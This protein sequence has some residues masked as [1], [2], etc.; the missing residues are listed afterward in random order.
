MSSNNEHNNQADKSEPANNAAQYQRYKPVLAHEIARI[1]TQETVK[2]IDNDLSSQTDATLLPTGTVAKTVYYVGEIEDISFRET[3][4]YQ[5]VQTSSEDGR[6]ST[7]ITFDNNSI[8]YEK[9]QNI[10]TPAYIAITGSINTWER[11]GQIGSKI[12]GHTLNEVTAQE[13]ARF[14]INASE[15]V[16][17]RVVNFHQGPP[18]SIQEKAKQYYEE[19]DL[20]EFAHAAE[21]ALEIADE[22]VE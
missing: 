19:I 17:D 16:L 11:N 22:L 5:W 13:R 2:V 18:T 8:D 15:S 12:I 6:L 7:I 1:E 21:Q 4:G 9:A 14:L 20:N 10:D 3:N